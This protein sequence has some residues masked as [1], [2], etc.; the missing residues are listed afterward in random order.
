MKPYAILSDIHLHKWSAFS[1]TTPEGINSRL[2]TLLRE[3]VRAATALRDAGGDTM[4]IAGD[5]FHVR[6][7]ISPSVLNPTLDTFRALTNGG[8]NV[9]ILPG[10]HDLEGMNSERV[11]NAVTALEGVGCVVHHRLSTI[12]IDGRHVSLMPWVNRIDNLKCEL[13]ELGADYAH[14]GKTLDNS[15]LI[16][17]APLN[18][19]IMGIPDHGLDPQYLAGL[20][21]NRVFC[22]HYHNHKSFPDGIYSIGAL[23]HHNWGDVGSQAGFLIVHEHQVDFHPSA[24]PQ[25]VDIEQAVDV[26]TAAK[27]ARGN[28]VRL[29]VEISKVSEIAKMR[30]FIMG[31]DAKGCVIVSVKKPEVARPSGSVATG[32]GSIESS[33]TS[34]V[35][36]ASFDNKDDVIVRALRVLAEV[37]SV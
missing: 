28:Y 35:N 33:V 36:A 34:Y 2:D 13:E 4:V 24:L 3:V 21:F 19:V 23:A 14:A 12:D 11:G 29:R 5:L 30:E 26:G 9:H 10:N 25:F 15:D 18:G 1:T 37:E 32:A 6:G 31:M 16:L 27:L 22:G 8:I 7:N 17:H 20:G